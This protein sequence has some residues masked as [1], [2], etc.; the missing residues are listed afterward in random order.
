MSTETFSPDGDRNVSSRLF[1]FIL[2]YHRL[3]VQKYSNHF[4][5]VVTSEIDI[6][7]I[8]YFCVHNIPHADIH[9]LV[10]KNDV[11]LGPTK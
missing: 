11:N 9:V 8:Y 5:H 1:F 6:H 4:V 10:I 2:C 7:Y 3:R